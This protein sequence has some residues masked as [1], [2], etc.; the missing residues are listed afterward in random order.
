M[1]I[2]YTEMSDADST[3][4]ESMR[5]GTAVILTFYSFFSSISNAS[6]ALSSLLL[7]GAGLEYYDSAVDGARTSFYVA[8]QISDAL[9]YH[10]QSICPPQNIIRVFC[11]CLIDWVHMNVC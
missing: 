5:D 2:H 11:I 3:C 9:S 6:L 4:A 10:H 8:Q 1:S 7:L